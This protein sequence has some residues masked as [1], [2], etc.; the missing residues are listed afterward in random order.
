MGEVPLNMSP[1]WIQIHG[2]PLDNLTLKNVV[3]I[4]KGMGSLIQV[5]DCSGE[6]KTFRSY[7]RI[8]VK[9]NVQ[10]PLK[11]GFLFCRADGEQFQISFKYERLDIYCSSCGRIG[12]KNQSCLAPPA[13]LVPGKYA[14]SLKVTI[15]SN[16]LPPQPSSSL[17]QPPSS[18]KITLIPG[19]GS[20][21]NKYLPSD[22]QTSSTINPVKK[23][24]QLP[25]HPSPLLQPPYSSPNS[26]EPTHTSNQHHFSLNVSPD[27]QATSTENQHA[28][29]HLTPL[30]TSLG[31]CSMTAPT[32]SLFPSSNS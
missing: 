29:A 19:E 23:L 14:I 10:E 13:E 32:S 21:A 16:L 26:L 25:P 9:L 30:I 1:F 28:V 15:F 20:I 31:T 18:Q 24:S 11:P 17:S 12:H 5:E 22:K 6:S 8:L 4:G 7:L 2:F 3:A 27:K